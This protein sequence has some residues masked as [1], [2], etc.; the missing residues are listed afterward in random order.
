MESHDPLFEMALKA[1]GF[2]NAIVKE[3]E[4]NV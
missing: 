2:D 1:A 3:K 4:V